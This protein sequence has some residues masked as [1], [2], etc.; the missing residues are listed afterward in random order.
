MIFDT[1][2]FVALP[3]DTKREEAHPISSRLIL[4]HF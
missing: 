1:A 4:F 2:F 3:F